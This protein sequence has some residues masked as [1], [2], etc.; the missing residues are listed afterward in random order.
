MRARRLRDS[1]VVITGASSGIGRATALRFARKGA[2][3]VLTASNE[4]ALQ[5]LAVE[6]TRLGAQ[7]LALPADVMD[8]N[9]MKDLAQLAAGAFRRIDVWVNNAAESLFV[10][11]EDTP[12][13]AFRQLVEA[14]LFG[15]VHG[16]R[17]ALPSFRQQGR[18]LLINVSSVFGTLGAPYLNAYATAKYALRGLSESLRKEGRDAHLRVV[19]VLPATLSTPLLK[20]RASSSRRAA[21]P[22]EPL[23]AA[24]R[25]AR[26]IV[27]SSLHPKREVYVN[28]TGPRPRLLR[29]LVRRRP[30]Q[31]PPTHAAA[32][33]RPVPASPSAV[34]MGERPRSPLRRGLLLGLLAVPLLLGWRWLAQSR[35]FFF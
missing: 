12:P 11:F 3:V 5:Q 32:G 16:A 19:T 7:A 10:R 6:C 26:A 1:V 28:G 30:F 14:S 27:R 31:A 22:L 8:E 25:V 17:A 13:E 23:Y 2:T 4:A 20:A 9:A 33:S 35:G 29:T 18:G 34:S 21:A 24:D 15:Y